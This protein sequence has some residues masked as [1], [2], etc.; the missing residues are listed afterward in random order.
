MSE[1]ETRYVFARSERGIFCEIY[2][3]KRAAYMGRIFNALRFGLNEN[4]VKLYLRNNV[5]ALL[6]EFQG[7]PALF[8]PHNYSTTKLRTTTPSLEE[9][10]ERV[11]MY[12]S[13][14]AGWSV[15]S[16]DGVFL[17][18][19]GRMD[20]EAVQAVRIMFRFESSFETHAARANCSDVLRS[21]LF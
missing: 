13:P 21:I 18:Q 16:V 17:K 9:A 5:R 10:L 15:Y 19:D 2:F 1:P 11:E 12:R 4:K 8:D 3:P 6:D 20:E 14:F 7:Y